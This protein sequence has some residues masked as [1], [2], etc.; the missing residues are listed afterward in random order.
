MNPRKDSLALWLGD[1]AVK[2][3]TTNPIEVGG[4]IQIRDRDVSFC[5]IIILIKRKKEYHIMA[6]KRKIHK[7]S[8][9]NLKSIGDRSPEEKFAIQSAGGKKSAENR[10]K[11]ANLRKALDLV[12]INQAP[13]P[14]MRKTLKDL[15]YEDTTEMAVMLSLIRKALGGDVGAIRLISEISLTNAEIQ[16]RRQIAEVENIEIRNKLLIA[17][18]TTGKEI[19]QDE[20]L[21]DIAK[22]LSELL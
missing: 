21:Q 17:S 18:D 12:L 5:A 10:R 11:K 15:G 22:S 1:T 13:T 20:R 3:Q 6:K 9:K 2:I 16:D 14:K 8:M 19:K 4:Y 7:N